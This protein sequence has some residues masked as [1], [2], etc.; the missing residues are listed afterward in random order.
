MYKSFYNL[1]RK[2]FEI[3]PDTS[4]LWL[5]ENHQE[6]LSTLRYGILDNKGFLLLTGD[7]GVGKTSLIKGLTKSFDDDV[8]WG[9]IDN[10]TLERIDFYN[11]IARNFGIDKKFTSKVQFLIQ[12]SHFLHKADDDNKKVLLLIDECH[13]LSQ[14]MLEELRLLSNIEKADAKLINIFFVGESSFT[15]LL[16]QPKNRAVRQR[17]TLTA[18]IPSLSSHETEDYIRHRLEVAGAREKIFSAKACQVVHRFS[19]GVPLEINKICDAALKLGANLEESIITPALV[20]TALNKVDLPKEAAAVP[21]LTEESFDNVGV[22]KDYSRYNVGG[23]PDSTVT[24]FNLEADHKAGWLKFGVAA[25]ALVVVG[26][27]F[28]KSSQTPVPQL[29]SSPEV[30]E[31]VVEPPKKLPVVPS[32]PA[33]AVLEENKGD[34]NQV[35]AEELKSAIL[36]KAYEQESGGD[37]ATPAVAAVT[38]ESVEVVETVSEVEISA[39]K[40]VVAEKEVIAD[41]ATD[42]AAEAIVDVTPEP[43]IAEETPQV[44]IEFVQVATTPDVEVAAEVVPEPEPV[45]EMEP[46]EPRK[47]LLPLLPSSLKLTKTGAKRLNSFVETLLDYPKATIL[48]KGFVSSKSN[49]AENIKLSEDRAMAVYK[50]MLKKGVDPEQI[51]IKGMGNREPIASN[52]TRAGR[53]KNRRVEILVISDGL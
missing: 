43:D 44:E 4:F 3:I 13:L 34:I 17:L 16:G 12:F 46:L 18:D 15:E 10:P 21:I 40:E 27:Y 11:E 48:V 22:Q 32:S 20:E 41:V 33:V 29:D 37:T 6:A 36:E 23:D 24:G 51:E 31:Q 5:G 45:V 2:P 38:S 30:V 42:V 28:F 39:D 52:D 25:L 35:K 47:V 14:E 49:S 19:G 1:D 50:M 9:V 8:E 7:A 53:A 26:G